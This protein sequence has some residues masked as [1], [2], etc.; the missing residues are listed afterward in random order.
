MAGL[1]SKVLGDCLKIQEQ[2]FT[3][4]TTFTLQLAGQPFAAAGFGEGEQTGDDDD[5]DVPGE[6]EQAGLNLR[7]AWCRLLAELAANG[8]E[9]VA[10]S[11]LAQ[12]R[13]NSTVFFRRLVGQLA[14]DPSPRPFTCIAPSGWD[15]LHLVNLPKGLESRVTALVESGW[16]LQDCRTLQSSQHGV[17]IK[18]KL[19]GSPWSGETGAAGVQIRQLLLDLV[20]LLHS[21]DFRFVA[22]INFKGTLDSFFFEARRSLSFGLPSPET[23]FA[24]SLN[25]SDRLR[26]ISAPPE[27]LHQVAGVVQQSWSRGI[28]A[29][30]SYHGCHEYKLGG[31]PWWA[32]GEQAVASRRLIGSLLAALK[33]TGWEVAATLEISR[34]LDDKSLLLFRQSASITRP[35]TSHKPGTLSMMVDWVS[36]SFHE[37]DKIRLVS[38]PGKE[39]ASQT[40][41]REKVRAR[42]AEGGEG[43]VQR[44]REYHG[45]TEWKLSGTPFSGTFG[46][47]GQQ[48]AMISFLSC[49]LRDF[50][51]SGWKLVTSADISAKYHSTKHERYPLD[52]H[53][54]FFL[55]VN[56]SLKNLSLHLK[57]NQEPRDRLHLASLNPP[58]HLGRLSRSSLSSAHHCQ[59]CHHHNIYHHHR[60]RCHHHNIPPPGT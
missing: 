45:A 4:A 47:G 16:G 40:S 28:Q 31:S 33:H 37:T 44:E 51:T 1:V 13:A 25:R 32:E 26:V 2:G 14:A 10:S 50:N 42:L 23:M 58:A 48:R 8:W 22:N 49:I 46:T 35:P 19:S 41:L 17:S 24:V 15:R 9:L 3:A 38:G 34:Q 57:S 30:R 55:Q 7:S 11:D 36:I 54:W 12:R 20:R 27:V 6:G 18:L 53:T 52:L 60:L 29:V 5:D 43:V 56:F 59:H 21:Q 39:T